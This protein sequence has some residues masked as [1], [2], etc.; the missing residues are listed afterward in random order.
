MIQDYY[1]AYASKLIDKP[2]AEAFICILALHEP[3][4]LER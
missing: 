4:M 2:P 3:D 1:R